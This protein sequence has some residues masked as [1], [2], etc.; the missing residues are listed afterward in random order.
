MI[1][2][3]QLPKKYRQPLIELEKVVGRH[4]HPQAVMVLKK[5]AQEAGG[6]EG[7]TRKRKTRDPGGGGGPI[8]VQG[9]NRRVK[10]YR[11]AEKDED[12]RVS[13]RGSS[14]GSIRSRPGSSDEVAKSASSS[15]GPAN[16]TGFIEREKE[17]QHSK[18]RDIGAACLMQDV[19]LVAMLR[20]K[21]KYV[22]EMRTKDEF[23]RFFEGM[24]KQ[25]A[26]KLFSKAYET[27]SD[28]E[29]EAKVKK[30]LTLL[31]GV[32]M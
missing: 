6:G 28:N 29:M 24:G 20:Q 19:E 22:P 32:L 2:T 11:N 18:T 9:L 25:R 17:K 4:L 27:L 13:S 16:G 26:E 10:K 30:R 8:K 21:P 1:P 14:R 15:L 12:V 7:L 31:E 5:Q 3:S 23:R